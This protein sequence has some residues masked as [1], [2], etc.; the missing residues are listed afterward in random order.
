[1]DDRAGEQRSGP[2]ALD[3]ALRG[4]AMSL[5]RAGG[6]APDPADGEGLPQTARLVELGAEWLVQADEADPGSL[7]RYGNLI[8]AWQEAYRLLRLAAVAAG[9]GGPLPRVGVPADAC[10]VDVVW[11]APPHWRGAESVFFDAGTFGQ[12]VLARGVLGAITGGAPNGTRPVISR[13]SVDDW[14]LW[15][16]VVMADAVIAAA[17]ADPHGPLVD[18]RRECSGPTFWATADK[19]AFTR[20]VFARALSAARSQGEVDEATLE[21]VAAILGDALGTT[22]P[23]L[24]APT[25]PGDATVEG[26]GPADAE[27]GTSPSPPPVPVGDAEPDEAMLDTLAKMTQ[28]WEG[29]GSEQLATLAG[30]LAGV[31]AAEGQRRERII[32]R[33]ALEIQRSVSK[34]GIYGSAEQRREVVRTMEA[35]QGWMT[36]RHVVV[37]PL[38]GGLDASRAEVEDGA[39]VH[40]TEGTA[41]R[42]V[43]PGLT[44]ADGRI[45]QAPLVR[46]LGPVTPYT[47]EVLSVLRQAPRV[48]AIAARPL[49]DAALRLA[50]AILESVEAGRGTARPSLLEFPLSSLFKLLHQVRHAASDGSVHPDVIAEIEAVLDALCQTLEAHHDLVADPVA[51]G[52]RFRPERVEPVGFVARS[53]E[54][55]TSGVVH[56]VVWP[57]LVRRS[58]QSLCLLG[59]VLTVR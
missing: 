18:A 44:L 58:D 42:I 6:P 53:S 25:D 40:F 36:A 24:P 9:V 43:V 23:E 15:R 27:P 1:M 19:R 54:H 48:L 14:M 47:A 50:T 22:G 26:A 45:L 38:D 51:I 59:G 2:A 39:D 31:L 8:D 3:A 17:A 12:V 56:E 49:R 5:E 37:Q 4:L 13:G 7:T 11:S 33:A 34:L 52:A 28:R 57:P 46:R 30:V 35:V 29:C 55:Q 10:A 16:N 20:R 21:A 32:A 41:A